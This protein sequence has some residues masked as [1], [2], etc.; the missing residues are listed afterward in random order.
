MGTGQRLTDCAPGQ[1]LEEVGRFPA[2]Q[3]DDVRLADGLDRS[4]VVGIGTI[5]HHDRL[6]LRAETR[7]MRHTHLRP[8]LEDGLAV[9]K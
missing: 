3:V 6:D 9:G 8:A 4:R 7:E 2:G 1:R 5:A